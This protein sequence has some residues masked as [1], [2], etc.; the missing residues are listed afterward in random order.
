MHH[1]NSTSISKLHK[2]FPYQRKR[3]FY[4]I[5]KAFLIIFQLE[6]RFSLT[7]VC[8]C[9]SENQ[10]KAGH[11]FQLIR[12]SGCLVTLSC[13]FLSVTPGTIVCQAPLSLGF[14]I[15]EYWSGM[16]FPSLRDL[17]NPGI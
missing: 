16:L 8:V 11:V 12:D 9:V 10:Q 1:H 6:D 7:Q 13:P 15:L 4:H 17:P 14:S 2:R 3:I 5:K